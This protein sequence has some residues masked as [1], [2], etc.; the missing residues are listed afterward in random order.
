MS[1]PAYLARDAGLPHMGSSGRGPRALTPDAVEAIM[2]CTDAVALAQMKGYARSYF[3][4]SGLI[5]MASGAA[6]VGALT[7]RS[8]LGTG[9]V[10]IAVLAGLG[11]IEARRRARQW[12]AAVDARL[13][14]LPTQ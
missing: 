2:R 14:T 10:A 7:G 8:R 9:G 3:A 4:M 1:T 13:A 6:V 5:V 11:V 12:E